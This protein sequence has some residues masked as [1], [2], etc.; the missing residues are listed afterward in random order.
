MVDLQGTVKGVDIT[1]YTNGAYEMI[2]QGE[3]VY[4][5][6]R[7]PSETPSLPSDGIYN[8]PTLHPTLPPVSPP[9]VEGE[10]VPREE[11]RVYANISRDQ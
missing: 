2:T 6:V 4:E 7:M 5:L 1:T 11:E 9:T 3:H 8:V 10:D